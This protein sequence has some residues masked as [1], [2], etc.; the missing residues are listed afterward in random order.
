MS[1]VVSME[2]KIQPVLDTVWQRLDKF[3]KLNDPI[4]LSIWASYFTYDVMGTLC[5]NEPLV[6]NVRNWKDP[7][8]NAERSL[9]YDLI[10][11]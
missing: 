9:D 7:H 1:A 10:A 3:A 4:N 2:D 8:A 11:S 6:E 5:L